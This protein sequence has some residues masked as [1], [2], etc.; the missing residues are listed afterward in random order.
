MPVTVQILGSTD[1]IRSTDYVRQLSL[2]YDGQS[3]TVEQSATYGGAPINRLGW[4][5][6]AVSC[7]AWSGKTVQEFYDAVDRFY[8]TRNKNSFEFIRGNIPLRHLEPLTVS[9]IKTAQTFAKTF[10]E[11][12]HERD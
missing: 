1:I 3:D 10:K 9:E 8:A 6:V 7:P 5:P 2:T 12:R 4:I 11:V